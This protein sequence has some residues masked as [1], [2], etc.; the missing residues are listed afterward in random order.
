MIKGQYHAF[1]TQR[2]GI[3][4]ENSRQDQQYNVVWKRT[5]RRSVETDI[6]EI[7]SSRDI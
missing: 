7:I 4:R 6:C 2:D 3:R 5:D 1:Q